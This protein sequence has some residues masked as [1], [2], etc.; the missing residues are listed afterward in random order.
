[1]WMKCHQF[2]E[3][4]KYRL[5]IDASVELECVSTK[6]NMATNTRLLVLMYNLFCSVFT[7]LR[8]TMVI[9]SEHVF[10]E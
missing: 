2:D 8:A 9:H 6:V 10:Y 5:S 7:R 1:M 3:D 4:L